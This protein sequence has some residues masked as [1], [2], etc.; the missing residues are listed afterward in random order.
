MITMGYEMRKQFL[1]F[2]QRPAREVYGCGFATHVDLNQPELTVYES[3]HKAYCFY[4]KLTNPDYYKQ[5]INKL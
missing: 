2:M 3:V 1:T 5:F 4:K